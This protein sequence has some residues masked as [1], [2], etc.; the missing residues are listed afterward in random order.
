MKLLKTIVGVFLVLVLAGAAWVYSGWYDVAADVPHT[1][2]VTTVLDTLRDRSVEARAAGISPPGLEARARMVSGAGHYD[3]MC[4]ACHLAPGLDDTELRR[5]LYPA[6]PRFPEGVAHGPDYNFWVIK[7]G[8]K[9]TAM[10]AWGETHG[11]EA[12]WDLA[13]FLEA[14]PELTPD[15]YHALVEA[16]GNIEAGEHGGHG[17]EDD[18]R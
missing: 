10:P 8:L 4:K 6:P 11:D 14:L 17:H 5:G 13:A 16:A 15:A 3:A 2:L 1:P 9:F 7:H 18:H 12:I